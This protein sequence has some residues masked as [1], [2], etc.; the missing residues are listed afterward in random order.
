[1]T[2]PAVLG[3]LLSVAS[4]LATPASADTRTETLMAPTFGHVAVYAPAGAPAHVVL[5][6]SGDGGWNLGVVAMAE[7]LRD[8]GALVIGIDIRTFIKNLDTTP[9]CGY[10][11]GPLEELARAIELHHKLPM[12]IPP[13]L[14]GYSSGA[15]LAYA[16]LSAA[17]AGTFEGA[18]SLGFCRDLEIHRMP[19][20]M[21]GLKA[22]K[23]P[24]AEGYDLSPFHGLTVPWIVLQGDIDQVCAPA[25]TQAFVAA[26]GSAR[27]IS[28]PRVGHG[29][30]VPRNWAAQFDEAYKA[31]DSAKPDARLTNVSDPEVEGLPLVSVPATGTSDRDR[32]RM[33][34]VLTGDGGWAELD[35][36]VARRLAAE[37]VPTVGWS[38]LRYYWTPR[39]PDAAAADL[40][41][42]IRHYANMWHKTRVLL[43]G[44]SFGADVL[45]FLVT[46]LPADSRSLIER[47]VLLGPSRAATFEFRVSSWF[48]GDRGNDYPTAPEVQRL[49]L[50]IICVRGIDENDSGCLAFEGPNIKSMTIGSGHHFSGEYDALV[51][52]ILPEAD[53][54]PKT[55]VSTSEATSR[56]SRRRRRIC[57]RQTS[58]GIFV[59][60][61]RSQNSG[62]TSQSRSLSASR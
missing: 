23:R 12:D 57:T 14:V 24:K 6:I 42:V 45:P 19:C 44:Y 30:S 34:I 55:W 61:Q 18:I 46:R 56:A 22:T 3:L 2:V 53:V 7:R 29:F 58:P 15:T 31:I 38:S 52:A 49:N 60:S 26:T 59:R 9:G 50:P 36:N 25:E 43:I 13:L 17:P 48:G 11:A 10:P 35:R 47:V 21:R 27:L 16:A 32:G 28:L 51:R 5:F 54:E 39:T 62:A 8:Q 1:M 40:D 4:T 37:G 41:R 20:Q 33:A